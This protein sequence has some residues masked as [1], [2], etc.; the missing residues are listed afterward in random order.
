MPAST[1]RIPPSLSENPESR[2]KRRSSE[3]EADAQ[4]GAPAPT[5]IDAIPTVSL[6]MVDE[7]RQTA[8]T[9]LD[10]TTRRVLDALRKKRNEMGR[11]GVFQF[12]AARLSDELGT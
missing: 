7:P 4:E 10:H 12:Q 6:S 11:N 3:D 9:S 1:V 8:K 2:K 5:A